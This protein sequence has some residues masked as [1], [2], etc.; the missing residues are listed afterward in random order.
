MSIWTIFE[1][2]Q[3]MVSR[4]TWGARFSCF[5]GGFLARCRKNVHI[6]KTAMISPEAKI[7]ARNAELHIGKNSSVGAGAV[8]QGA[9]TIGENCSIQMYSIVSAYKQSPIVIGNNVRMAS[10][11]MMVSGNHNFDDPNK[12]IREQGM[13]YAPITIE[14][15]VWV[16]SRVNITAG[17]T[18]GHGSVIGAGAV[19]TK[20]VP[21]YSIMAGVPAKCIGIRGQKK[22]K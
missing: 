17:V 19:V 3:S 20:D 8:V 10:H 16:A 7:C 18:I 4:K 15:D 12:P 1:G 22:E 6:D 5:V 14:D 2:G 21:P 11:C 9:V 13:K